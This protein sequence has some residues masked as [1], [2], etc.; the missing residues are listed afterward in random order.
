[1]LLIL[2]NA[3]STSMVVNKFGAFQDV[4]FFKLSKLSMST[5]SSSYRSNTQLIGTWSIN[6]H[7]KKILSK[8]GSES[9]VMNSGF[10]PESYNEVLRM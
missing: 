6:D 4:W 9:L 3:N 7:S 2:S 10:Y 1:M 8:N 5:Q